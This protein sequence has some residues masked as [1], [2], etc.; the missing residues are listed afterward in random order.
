MPRTNTASRAKQT[1]WSNQIKS[2]GNP[3]RIRSNPRKQPD[4]IHIALGTLRPYHPLALL[5]ELD[6][7]EKCEVIMLNLII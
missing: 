3:A 4:C 2:S 7:S 1:C 5:K 6:A